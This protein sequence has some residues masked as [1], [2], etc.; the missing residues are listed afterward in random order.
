LGRIREH[1]FEG[2][3]VNDVDVAEVR[4][5]LSSVTSMMHADGYRLVVE[6]CGDGVSIAIEAHNDACS[7]CL[8]PESVVRGIIE[9]KL[10]GSFPITHL[11]YPK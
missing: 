2:V 9:G 5:R 1:L 6:P 8:A 7:E 11:T 3:D 10:D 4:S